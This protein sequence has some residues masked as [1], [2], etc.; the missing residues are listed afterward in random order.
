MSEYFNPSEACPK[1]KELLLH[2]T[3]TTVRCGPC[4]L[5]NPDY[6]ESP[7]KLPERSRARPQVRKEV[8]EIEESPPVLTPV[9]P[10]QA[11]PP[12]QRRGLAIQIPTVP[13]LKLG[14]AEKERQ[15]ADQRIAERKAKTGFIPSIPIIHFSVGVAHWAYDDFSDDEGYWAAS[16]NQWSVDEDNRQVTS[17][18]LLASLLHRASIQTKRANLKKWLS[19]DRGDWSLGH[20]NPTKVAARD[21]ATWEQARLLSVVI[22]SGSYEQK[23]VP[24]TARKL[25]TIWLYWTPEAPTL[26]ECSTPTARRSTKK[27]VKK[28]NGMK[29]EKDVKVEPSTPLMAKRPRPISTELS[30]ELSTAKR[31]G[32]V[33]RRQAKVLQEEASEVQTLAEMLE[34]HAEGAGEVPG[35]DEVDTIV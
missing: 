35:D 24:G 5:L 1:S 27:G 21:V 30:T 25:V 26:V 29:A 12:A 20:T 11:I 8:I 6:V 23:V 22:D 19:C 18:T 9:P 2:S 32:T 10:P 34:D 31:P 33:T 16:G 15:H 4:T 17:D 28:E 14:Y 13:N 7:A 3:V